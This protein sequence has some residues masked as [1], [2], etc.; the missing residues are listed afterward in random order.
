M[1]NF[2]KKMFREVF[3][4]LSNSMSFRSQNNNFDKAPRVTN[5]SGVILKRNASVAIAAKTSRDRFVRKIVTTANSQVSDQLP[6]SQQVTT[7]AK[8]FCSR[9]LILRKLLAQKR[10]K[11]TKFSST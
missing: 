10:S 3:Q 1:K 8:H 2:Y 7:I 5:V 6:I 11:A 9:K 4:Y